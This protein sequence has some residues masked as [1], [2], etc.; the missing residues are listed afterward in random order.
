MVSITNTLHMNEEQLQ[1][2]IHSTDITKTCRQ[3]IKYKYRHPR[4]RARM[5][6]SSMKKD[7]LKAIRSKA[8]D[9]FILITVFL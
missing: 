8:H 9:H 4:R 5:L 2:C 1:S 7:V 6:I 3:I